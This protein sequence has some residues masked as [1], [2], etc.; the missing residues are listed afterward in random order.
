[1]HIILLLSGNDEYD[2]LYKQQFLEKD[3]DA[4]EKF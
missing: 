4:E 2:T 3:M 1:M